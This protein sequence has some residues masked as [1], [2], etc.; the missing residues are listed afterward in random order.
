MF[1]FPSSIRLDLFYPRVGD[2]E[3]D[4]RYL[5][6]V[7]GEHRRDGRGSLHALALVKGIDDDE[8]WNFGCF[9]WANNHFLHLGT[10]RL[11][12]N[13]RVHLQDSEQLLSKQGI[14]ICEL[15]RECREDQPNVA[16]FLETS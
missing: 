1:K 11:L 8:G 7:A 3:L 14:P 12:A 13:L 16:S 9:E 5:M 10:K 4:L 15:K 6:H 2:K